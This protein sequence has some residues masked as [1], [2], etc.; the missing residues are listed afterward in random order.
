MAQYSMK[1]PRLQEEPPRTKAGGPPEMPDPLV[2]PMSTREIIDRV[3]RFAE[4]INDRR[5]Y[6]YQA[7]FARR[8]V[9]SVLVRDGE[10][11]TG[12]F[13]RQ[14]GKTEVCACLG[15][16]LTLVL[17]A[18]AKAFPN[19][20]RF[21]GF[22]DGF[23]VGIF[24]PTAKHSGLVYLRMRTRVQSHDFE[25]IMRDP[26]IDTGLSHSRG[27]S[28]A[29][30]NGSRVEA[31]TASE[32]VLN[33]GGTYHLIFVDE[34]QK[35]SQTKIDKE[36][37]PMLSKSNGSMVLIGTAYVSGGAFFRQIRS[38]IDNEEKTKVRNHFQFD[39]EQVIRDRRALYVEDGNPEHIRYEQWVKKE[40]SRMGGNIDDEAFR[41]N[42]RLLWH[43]SSTFAFRMSEIDACGR[44][45]LE[46]N[47]PWFGRGL[48]VAGMDIGKT[49]DAT[50]L[51]VSHVDT[52][53]P[54]VEVSEF[55][56]ERRTTVR[57]PWCLIGMFFM[58]GDFEGNVGQYERAKSFLS[59]W[60]QLSILVGDGTGKGDVVLERMATLLPSVRVIPY[61]FTLASKSDGYKRYMQ[62]V[63]LRQF[64]YAHGPE[65]Q[66]N[67]VFM[68]WRR[69]HE[70]LVKEPSGSHIKVYA[71]DPDDHDDAPD[72][73][74]LCGVASTI[75]HQSI[76]LVDLSSSMSSVNVPS[77]NIESSGSIWSNMNGGYAH[78]KQRGRGR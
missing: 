19:D 5:F 32:N 13:S 6:L 63:G 21:M 46:L 71:S 54:I 69:Q 73:T 62:S 2:C 39:Y 18:L 7:R 31:H 61:V 47:R 23:A 38:N 4:L 78:R 25:D 26:G 57:Y 22:A 20:K 52:D 48:I 36:L 14:S 11:L 43:D 16:A 72:A 53:N 17:P 68:E 15:L 34:S 51:V 9:E 60:P 24:A 35:I 41:M 33:E 70:L 28:F 58:Q 12:L 77:V 65:T 74:M 56:K 76:P 49:R 44:K 29:F 42:F 66:K 40:L 75:E 55:G 1:V 37:R 45:D 30:T 27:D 8:I 59:L 50:W 64:S 67:A 10:T 3:I